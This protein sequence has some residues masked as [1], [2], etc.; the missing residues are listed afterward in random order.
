MAQAIVSVRVALNEDKTFSHTGTDLEISVDE[1][2]VLT[3]VDYT[4]RTDKVFSGVVFIATPGYWKTAELVT[5]D[6]Q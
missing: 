3:V 2:G 1:A 6:R 4:M 5:R